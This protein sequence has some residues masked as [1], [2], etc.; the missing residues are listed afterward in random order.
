MALSTNDKRAVFGE[1]NITPLTDIFLV[2]LIIMMVVAP[3]MDNS[4]KDIKV[5]ELKNGVALEQN[6]LTVEVTKEGEFFVKE[7]PVAEGQLT[8]SLKG[9]IEE[10]KEKNVVIRAD[11][12]TKSGTI[13]KIFEAARDA[14]Y[15]KVTV[16]GESLDQ[17]RASELEQMPAAEEAQ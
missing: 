15:E 6:R 11:K 8:D 17:K 10:V 2:L 12:A 14:G 3:M 5:P 7:K 9:Y 1:I 4:R 16:S 13:M